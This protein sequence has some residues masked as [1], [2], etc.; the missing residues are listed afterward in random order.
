[1]RV[2]VCVCVCMS[3]SVYAVRTVSTDKILRFTNTLI[4]HYYYRYYLTLAPKHTLTENV[5]S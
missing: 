2:C 3:A 5:L 4:I 1:M